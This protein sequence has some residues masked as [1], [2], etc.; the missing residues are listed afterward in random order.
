MKKS[1]IK[2]IRVSGGYI[3]FNILSGAEKL[4][5]FAGA[6]RALADSLE[7]RKNGPWP[8]K[9]DRAL[10]EKFERIFGRGACKKTFGTD[11]P[12]VPQFEE[13]WG[14]FEPLLNGWL[15]EMGV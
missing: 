4:A 5:G 8:T 9:A 14:K 3:R 13:F 10:A 2:K 15:E 7:G 11:I 6:A 12:S 1:C